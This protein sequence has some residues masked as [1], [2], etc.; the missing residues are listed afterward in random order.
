[1]ATNLVQ[2]PG[3][4]LSVVV[5]NPAAPNSGDPVRFGYM[6]GM[7]ITDDGDGGTAAT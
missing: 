5:T 2:D 4:V 7:A 6:P 1:M 3:K